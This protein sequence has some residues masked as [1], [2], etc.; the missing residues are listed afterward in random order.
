M[1]KIA[2]LII[3]VVSISCQKKGCT[4]ESAVNFS[5]KYTKDNGSCLYAQTVEP[6]KATIPFEGLWDRQFEA[7]TGTGAWH[8]VLYS[9]YQDSIRYSLSGPIGNSDYTMLRDTFILEYNRY[10]GHT[11]ANVYYLIFTSE[12]TNDSIKIYKEII[13]NFD[14]GMS[15]EVPH[16]TSTANHGWSYYSK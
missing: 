14:N 3:L 15:I 9:I 6:I 16:D 5:S 7:G 1:K 11:T 8:T 12:I 2:Y 13:P 10:I 4:D